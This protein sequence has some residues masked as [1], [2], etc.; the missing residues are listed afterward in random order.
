MFDIDK[1]LHIYH[2]GNLSHY[3]RKIKEADSK[4]LKE[5]KRNV[6][7]H[8]KKSRKI[9]AFSDL[10]NYTVHD[11]LISVINSELRRRSPYFKVY[12][13]LIPLC[14]WIVL[15]TGS[16]EIT[17]TNESGLPSFCTGL[18]INF[19]FAP[20]KMVYSTLCN[21]WLRHWKFVITTI[22]AILGL[23]FL[24][25]RERNN[26]GVST[27]TSRPYVIFDANTILND[28]GA[29]EYLEEIEVEV[30]GQ[31]YKNV[32]PEEKHDY[33]LEITITPKQ[34]LAHA[35]LIEPLG[36]LRS[37]IIYD[38]KRGTKYQWVYTVL[39]RPPYGGDIKTQKFRLEILR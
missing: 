31:T 27:N 25:G 20:F 8:R 11:L 37:M 13:A 17:F 1:F 34:Y 21:F 7:K 15:K 35:P 9:Q 32:K 39:V 33:L 36:G 6:T 23:I 24:F 12:K 10:K 22:I 2:V 5:F 16:K 38:G 30:T 14:R 26:L 4:S 29:M 18:N 3:F 19:F 28:G